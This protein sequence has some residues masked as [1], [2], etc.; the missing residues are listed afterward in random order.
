MRVL[1]TGANGFVGRALIDLLTHEGIPF[2]ATSRNGENG[3]VPIGD[4]NGDTNWYQVLDGVTDVIHLAGRAHVLNEKSTDPMSLFRR[5]NVEGSV[6]LA[7]A[8]FSCG[9]KR[10]VFVSSIGAVGDQSAIGA[11]LNENS[12]CHPVSPYG[13]SKLEA[14]VKLREIAGRS[15]GE[16]VIVRPPLVYGPGAPGNIAKMARW[17]SR[18]IPLPLAGIDNLRSLIHVRNLADALVRCMTH[19]DA[20]G[21]TFH[22]RDLRDYSTPQILEGAA[23]ALG[24]KSRLYRVPRSFLSLAAAVTGQQDAVDRLLGNLQVDDFSI[25]RELSWI[26]QELPFEV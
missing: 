1:I 21:K 8:S 20:S 22:V 15:N 17:V 3:S 2:V 23:N 10:L 24:C 19:P 6:G 12:S 11:P 18:G 26:P 4:I 7:N 16:L 14:E 5:T 13:I 9:V 25:R